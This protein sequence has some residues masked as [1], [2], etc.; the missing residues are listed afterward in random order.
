M[1]VD[2]SSPRSRSGRLNV[3]RRHHGSDDPRVVELHREV[4]ADAIAR[5]VARVVDAAPPLSDEQANRIA[6]LLRSPAAA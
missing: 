5:Y 2:A 6:A 3:M 4:A 1:A